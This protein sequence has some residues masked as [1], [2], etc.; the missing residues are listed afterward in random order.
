M[1]SIQ[2]G[3]APSK[4]GLDSECL[5]SVMSECF[6]F[7]FIC[8]LA[9]HCAHNA[10]CYSGFSIFDFCFVSAL[11]IEVS[12]PYKESERFYHVFMIGV[13]SVP[14]IIIVL[15]DLQDKQ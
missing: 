11:L 2:L 3:L 13:S 8:L 15:L 12:V 1:A 9:L 4:A 6:C 5:F 14:L 10:A 7:V